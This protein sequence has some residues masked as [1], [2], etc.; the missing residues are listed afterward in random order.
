MI[1]IKLGEFISVKSEWPDSI[2]YV[3]SMYNTSNNQ[4]NDEVKAWFDYELG[5][6]PQNEPWRDYTKYNL[7]NGVK[8][9]FGWNSGPFWSHKDIYFKN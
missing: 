3:Y 7:T 8:N 4:L 1:E 5:I 2:N 9:D 6:H